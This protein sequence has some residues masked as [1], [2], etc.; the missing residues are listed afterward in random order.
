MM[1]F[2]PGQ[3]VN[4]VRTRMP[5]VCEFT[6]GMGFATGALVVGNILPNDQHALKKNQ[7]G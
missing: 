6:A 5:A 1:G 2:K 3:T 4:T 7:V